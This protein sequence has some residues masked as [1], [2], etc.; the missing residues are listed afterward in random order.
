MLKYMNPRSLK[1]EEP[2]A[3]YIPLSDDLP[4]CMVSEKK[5]TPEDVKY[6]LSSHYQGTEYD[7]YAAYGEKSMHGTFR[8]FG[9]NR[10]DFMAL[11]QMRPDEEKDMQAIEWVAYASNAFNVMA[12]FYTEL[13]KTPDYLSGTAK[14]VSTDNFYRVSC[15]IAAM[16]KKAVADTLDKVLYELSNDMK[17]AYSGS[18]A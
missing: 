18:D 13:T 14:E 6:L 17:N 16:V 11:I 7:P 5:V 2:D 15:M 1:W 4:W 8:S 3:Q 12:Y 10:N 9:I